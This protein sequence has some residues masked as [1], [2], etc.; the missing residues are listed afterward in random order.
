MKVFVLFCISVES[1]RAY[2]ALSAEEAENFRQNERIQEI[3]LRFEDIEKFQD[4]QKNKELFQKIQNLNMINKV[5]KN[6]KK[7]F[8]LKI[9]SDK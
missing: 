9:L 4:E 2:S 6:L 1:M 5:R 8:D 3:K 7:L